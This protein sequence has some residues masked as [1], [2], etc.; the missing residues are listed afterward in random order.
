MVKQ[1]DTNALVKQFAEEVANQTDAMWSGDARAGNKHAKR[2]I[3]AF[4]KLRAL[5]DSGRDAL[6][7]LL[8]HERPDVRV[9]AAAYL[10]RHRT[11]EAMRVLQEA[12]KGKSL[13]AFESSEAIKRWKEGTWAL[14]PPDGSDVSPDQH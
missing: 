9:T 2:Y 8:T 13:I 14:D 1:P 4:R 12:S 6:A 7:V 5:G 10:L 11:L 3:A